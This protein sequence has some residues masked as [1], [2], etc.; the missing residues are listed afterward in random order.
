MVDGSGCNPHP[1]EWTDEKIGRFWD[2]AS[3]SP[4]FISE[5]FSRMVGEG[6]LTFLLRTTPVKGRVLDYGC[7]PGYLIGQMLSRGIACE[8]LDFSPDSVDIVNQRYQGRPG[9]KGARTADSVTADWNGAFDVILCLETIEHV[10][11]RRLEGFLAELH[12]LLKPGAGRLFMTT[13]FQEDLAASESSC[14][15]C[16]CVFHRMQHVRSFTRES[17]TALMEQHGFATSLCEVTDFNRFQAPLWPGLLDLNLR[18][19]ARMAWSGAA[20][21]LDAC[22]GARPGRWAGQYLGKGRNLF[23]LGGTK[24]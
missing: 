11:P 20:L 14:P 1:V 18:R 24:V 9:W 22:T 16:G 12:R 7:G 21:A 2:H 3:R 17:L 6:V 10:L 19:L 23:W 4:E 8:G 5:Y 15:D 13:P